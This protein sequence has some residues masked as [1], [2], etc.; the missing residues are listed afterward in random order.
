M[1]NGG[2]WSYP[3]AEV[4]LHSSSPL[5]N[6]AE[7]SSNDGS[8]ADFKAMHQSKPSSSINAV[9]AL[10]EVGRSSTL[11]RSS[12]PLSSVVGSRRQSH[13]RHPGAGPPP[14]PV[15]NSTISIKDGPQKS[16]TAQRDRSEP[17]PSVRMLPAR[18]QK[19]VLVTGGAGFLGSHLV[20]RL[21]RMG[22]DVLV[23][24]NFFTGQKSNVSHWVSA[25]RKS[26]EVCYNRHLKEKPALL[27]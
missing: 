5:R 19:R 22:H 1:S 23:L 3:R 10:A 11:F 24:D 7:D 21:M 17:F 16:F 12:S 20:D 8:S 18:E 25:K 27:L 15:S 2:T 14:L 4:S 9:E 26:A 6:N 13:G